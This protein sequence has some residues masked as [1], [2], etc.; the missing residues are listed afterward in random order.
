MHAP[1]IFSVTLL[2]GSS[3]H[4]AH[5][6]KFVVQILQLVAESGTGSFGTP[7]SPSDISTESTKSAQEHD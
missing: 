2:C 5:Q 6:L 4:P 3:A 1:C 7:G